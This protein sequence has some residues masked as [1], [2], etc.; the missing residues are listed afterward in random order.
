MEVDFPGTSI[1]V[2]GHIRYMHGILEVFVDGKSLGTRDMYQPKKWPWGHGQSS[3]VWITGLE[4]GTHTLRI[5]VT[6]KKNTDSE[7]TKIG[8]GRI[9]CYRGDIAPL[10]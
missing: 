10:P 3:A 9:A 4:D 2:Q 6:G 5:V 1:Y 8:L 7:G